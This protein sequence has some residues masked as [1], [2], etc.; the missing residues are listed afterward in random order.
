MFP[1]Y[2]LRLYYVRKERKKIKKSTKERSVK[3]NHSRK[4]KNNGISEIFLLNLGNIKT[5]K[6]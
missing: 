1:P 3:L 2:I 4:E 5:N 6:K